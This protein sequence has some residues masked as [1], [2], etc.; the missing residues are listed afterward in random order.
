[1]RYANRNTALPVGGGPDGKS[2]VFVA[3]GQLI[4][5]GVFSMHR[6]KDLYGED[7][8]EYKPERWDGLRVGWEYLPFS[9]GPRICVGKQFALTEAAYT[10]VGMVQEFERVGSRDST[11]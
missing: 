5:Y 2:P 11:P 9:G 1:M 3:K 6:R 4:V 7:A 8:D 10:L